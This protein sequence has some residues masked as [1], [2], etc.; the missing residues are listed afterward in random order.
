MSCLARAWMSPAI[1]G[2]PG[3]TDALQDCSRCYR[4]LGIP[5]TMTPT[6]T[7]YI[8]PMRPAAAAIVVIQ[9]AVEP[10]SIE[11]AGSARASASLLAMLAAIIRFVLSAETAACLP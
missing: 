7:I 9:F 5:Y 3:M 4:Y 8:R 1:G 6:I 11:A 2:G 10:F